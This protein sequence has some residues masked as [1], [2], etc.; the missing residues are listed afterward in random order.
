[1]QR[2]MGYELSDLS[3]LKQA[4]FDTIIDVRSPSEFAEDHLPG[5]IN[6]PVLSD[7]ERAEVGTIYAKVS[8]FMARKVGAALVARNAAHHLEGSLREM[9]GG[10]RPLIY[11]WRGGQRSGSFA[12]I[13]A[14]IGWRVEVLSGGY[15]S[16]RRLVV[17][18]LYRNDFPCPV[19]LLDGNTGTAK[20][21]VIRRLPS[22]QIQ[23]INLEGLANHRGSAL[24][25][26]GAQPGQK[27]FES[28]LANHIEALDPGKPVVLE[29]ESS[30]I[31]RLNLPPALISAMKTAR[32]LEISAPLDA[33]AAYLCTAYA[34]MIEDVP[35][36]TDRLR[37]LT[38]L[39]GHDR[40]N[41]W[42][43]LAE[44]GA[45]HELAVQLIRDHYD[46]RYAKVRARREIEPTMV[47]AETLDES[48]IQ[49]L[50]A[51]IAEFAG[52]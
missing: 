8:P 13:L 14:Q 29:A 19:I 48:G 40:V 2:R 37:R 30:R 32:R 28:A 38:R 17:E 20:T 1:M 44:A 16:Y 27:A 39:Q 52:T 3:A 35:L 34:D 7:S 12:S 26:Y 43:A 6:L 47:E 25:A 41:D 18:R 36:L 46:P 9:E 51:R 42:I 33:R 49:A 10:W 4:G 22:L 11:C 23:S 15:Q 50:T 5:A 21:E 45:F 31:G 24:G